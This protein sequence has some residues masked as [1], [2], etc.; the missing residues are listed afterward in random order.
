MEGY[1]RDPKATGEAIRD[2]WFHTG[3]IGYLDEAGNLLVTGRIKE[4]IVTAGGKN[5]APTEVEKYYQGL[6]GVKELAVVGIPAEG[7][8]G[9]EIHAAGIPR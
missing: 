1:F 6:P 9:D 2:G 5:A 4:I 8:T 3:D 7:R